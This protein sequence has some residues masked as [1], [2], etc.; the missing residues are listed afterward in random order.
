MSGSPPRYT[1]PPIASPPPMPPP[2]QSFRHGPLQPR[3]NY[4]EH[5]LDSVDMLHPA[6]GGASTS[7]V[8][9]QPVTDMPRIY[10]S[11]SHTIHSTYQYTPYYP[12]TAHNPDADS[13]R[14]YLP[15]SSSSVSPIYYD[16][17]YYY[18]VYG[19]GWLEDDEKQTLEL[20]RT[21]RLR[22]YNE[23]F[24]TIDHEFTEN[25]EVI[26]REKTKQLQ[27]ELR[28]VEQGEHTVF[29]EYMVDF[30]QERIQMIEN[31]RMMMEHQ[32]RQV[33]KVYDNDTRQIQDELQAEKHEIQVA[34][35]SMLEAK[36][37]QLKDDKDGEFRI[38][39]T[40]DAE[41]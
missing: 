27:D 29:D 8:E 20:E 3:L 34:M 41:S 40:S 1:L 36:R 13:H 26:Y 19:D 9:K 21:N 14:P 32:L 7:L 11:R 5:S 35:F 39:Y 6:Q 10:H 31:A 18:P 12:Y 37:K 23:R 24:E 38:F 4:N 17:M 25:R 22:E 33:D 30:E 28:A 2:P 15:E 16:G